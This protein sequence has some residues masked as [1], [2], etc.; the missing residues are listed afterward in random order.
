MSVSGTKWFELKVRVNS[1]FVEPTVRL[2]SKYLFGNVVTQILNPEEKSDLSSALNVEVI[3][4]IEFGE[5]FSECLT[6]LKVGLKLF[7]EIFV[8]SDLQQK[9]IFSQLWEKQKF[10]SI[11]IGNKMIIIPK[12]DEG[13]KFPNKLTAVIEPS[14]AFGTGHHAT[15]RMCVELLE[16]YVKG[17]ETVIDLGCGS[18]ILALCSLLLGSSSVLCVDNDIAAIKA[19]RKNFES[20]GLNGDAKFYHESLSNFPLESGE[21]DIVLANL[22]ANIAIENFKSISVKIRKTGILII[23]G[24]LE[25]R[26]SEVLKLYVKEGLEIIEKAQSGNWVAAVLKKV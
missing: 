3:G 9:E 10:N 5:H 17:G 16:K 19:A 15:T 12:E 1:E 23:S 22:T 11:A 4:Y 25:S 26:F 8:I 2:F 18:G 20:T 7:Q 24:I 21:F 14:M 6:N 13:K